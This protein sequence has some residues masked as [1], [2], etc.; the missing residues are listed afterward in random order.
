M[1]RKENVVAET[2]LPSPKTETQQEG[3]ELAARLDRIGVKLAQPS[4]EVRDKLR[5]GQQAVDRLV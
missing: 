1:T 2:W 3:F 4:A 5:A